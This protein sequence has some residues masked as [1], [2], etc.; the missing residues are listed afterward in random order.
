MP[1]RCGTPPASG[2][3][4]REHARVRR[5]RSSPRRASPG[6]PARS[7]VETTT[8]RGRRRATTARPAHRREQPDVPGVERRAC[9]HQQVADRDVVAG[10]TDVLAGLGR[11]VDAD[12]RGAAIG[13]FV[14]DDRVGAV[15]DRGAGHDLGGVASRQR[16]RTGLAGADL[17]HDRQQHRLVGAG[18]GHVGAVDGVPVHRRVVEA[19]QR[20]R[21]DDVLGADQPER[22]EQGNVDGRHRA[23]A[24]E[25]PLE[26]RLDRAGLG[27]GHDPESA[28]RTVSAGIR[29]ALSV[30]S[31]TSPTTWTCAP[32]VKS[33]ST[34]RLVAFL[35][36]GVP[37][38]KR[39]SNSA[40]TL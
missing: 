4:G 22:I 28:V 1:T 23:D 14:G 10:R 36:E 17:A 5:R 9:L 40:T 15:G 12:L 24:G 31:S 21:R 33:P 39:L 37:S 29:S 34:V 26:M 27:I 11:L 18:A 13:P 30:V 19:G 35:I 38:G 7:P 6:A 8:T 2:H 25:H 20:H 16:A 32:K 3:R